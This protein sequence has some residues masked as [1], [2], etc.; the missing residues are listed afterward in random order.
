MC[1]WENTKLGTQTV[2]G[3][4]LGTEPR[5]KG[6]RILLDFWAVVI[7]RSVRLVEAVGH[8]SIASA[9]ADDSNDEGDDA[10][11]HAAG[12]ME[13]ATSADAASAEQD[14]GY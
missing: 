1:C 3:R 14:E 11:S 13:A 10:A 5:T 2:N 6:W 9:T 7:W 8:Y 12:E 4:L